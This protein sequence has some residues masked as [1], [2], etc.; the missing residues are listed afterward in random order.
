MPANTSQKLLIRLSSLGDVVLAA[1]ALEVFRRRG[2]K[3]D[4]LVA[5]EFA[6]LLEGHPSIRRLWVYDRREGFR[7]WWR[8]AQQLCGQNYV[9]V[10]DLH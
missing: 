2:E 5:R 1:A 9:D 7:G 3:V 10:F 6:P 4:W 8:L